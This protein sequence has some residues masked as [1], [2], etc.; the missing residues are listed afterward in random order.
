MQSKQAVLRETIRELTEMAH[1][2]RTGREAAKALAKR[3]LYGEKRNTDPIFWPA[4]LLLLGLA[5]AALAGE[6]EAEEAAVSYL[7]R[8]AGRDPVITHTD[9]AV[10]CYA[11]LRL[12]ERTGEPKLKALCDA[13]AAF[14]KR[15][16]RDEQGSIVYNAA[17]GN[18]CIFAD[19]AGQTALF[20]CAYGAAFGREEAA[21]DAR[22]Q[23]SNWFSLG[24]D[25]RTGL[26]YHGYEAGS[27]CCQGI[28]GWGRA[29]G[30]LLLG[31]AE[32]LACDP[33]GELSFPIRKLFAAVEAYGRPDGLFAWT[34]PGTR[35]PADTSATGMIRW[36]QKRA[37]LLS[38]PEKSA[39]ALLACTEDSG[40]VLQCSA[41]C[42]DFGQYVQQYGAYPWGQGAVCAA[43]WR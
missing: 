18:R 19:G 17:R 10:A 40:R 12:Y 35:G 2:R 29:A 5:E 13:C 30:W 32:V 25:A 3:V 28:V 1:P 26:P 41:E 24:M 43:L 31:A 38:D 21:A 4:G 9:D 7:V 16:L 6:R 34:L 14:L 11:A 39:R 36:A 27:G 33:D 22:R 8:A 42:I 37:G 20:L 15:A 23:L